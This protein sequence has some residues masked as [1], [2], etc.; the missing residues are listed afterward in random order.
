MQLSGHMVQAAVAGTYIDLEVPLLR[1]R[2]LVATPADDT[3]AVG[4]DVSNDRHL[5]REEPIPSSRRIAVR[6]EGNCGAGKVIRFVR[7]GDPT[8][9][10]VADDRLLVTSPIS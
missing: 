8:I 2:P 5:V 6:P 1:L 10:A 4:E 9:R 3:L 7:R